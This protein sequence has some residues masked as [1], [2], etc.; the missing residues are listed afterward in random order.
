M[1]GAF[2]MLI[3]SVLANIALKFI[4][5]DLAFVIRIWIVFMS[6]LV[7]GYVTSNHSWGDD[8]RAINLGG[9]NFVT[10]QGFNQSVVSL[11]VILGAIYVYFW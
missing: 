10:T 5:P 4:T 8:M 9:M 1:Q 6:C 3:V 7:V 11:T 2:A